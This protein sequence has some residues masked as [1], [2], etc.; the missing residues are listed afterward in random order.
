MKSKIQLYMIGNAHIDPVWLWQRRE[1]LQE[2]KATFRSAV[3][4][5]AEYDDF[6]FTASSAAFYK[7]VELSDPSMFS[8][9][10]QRVAEGRWKITGGYWVE[11][12]CNIPSGESFIRQGLYGQRYFLA[13]VGQRC[14]TGFNIDSFG[15]ASMLPQLLRGCG[16]SFYCFLRPGPH[17]K[18]L[19]AEVFRWE[20]PDGSSVLCQRINQAYTSDGDDLSKKLAADSEFAAETGLPLM[21]F[22]GVGNHGGGP[23][24]RNIEAVRNARENGEYELQFSG[25]DEYF[26]SIIDGDYSVPVQHGELL[27]HASGCYAA[28]SS[29]KALNRRAEEALLT[30][31]KFS[32][33]AARLT[34]YRETEE[35]AFL[36]QELLFNQ[37]HDILAGSSIESACVDA[38][39]LYVEILSR[40]ER[41][42]NAA[43]Q[44]VSWRTNI[45]GNPGDRFFFAANPAAWSVQTLLEAEIVKVQAGMRLLG[46]GGEEVPFQL[47]QSEA[48]AKGRA[49]IVFY[50]RLP[51]LGYAVYRL[52]PGP[53][54]G[55]DDLVY[56]TPNDLNASSLL[57]DS[58]SE[59][60]S[61]EVEPG[62]R[63]NGNGYIYA[64]SYYRLGFDGSR[65]LTEYS[66]T[67]RGGPL[68]GAGGVNAVVM[69]DTSDTWSH[70]VFRYDNREGE[71]SFDSIKVLEDGRVRSRIRISSIYNG[72]LLEQDWI[73]AHELPYVD[74]R[75]RIVWKGSCKTVKLALPLSS[76]I[77]GLR[78][79]TAYAEVQRSA[80]G[81][82]YPHHRYLIADLGPHKPSLFLM[83]DGK[84][85]YSAEDH[86]VYLTIL[87]SPAFSHHV[88]VTL[89]SDID[90]RY[91]DQGEQFFKCR[92]AIIAADEAG[93]EAQISAR[94]FA[95]ELNQSPVLFPE[96][97]HSG[98]LSAASSFLTV[99][100]D[101]VAVTAL[102][103]AEDGGV[104]VLRLFEFCGRGCR[105]RLEFP[106]SS[107]CFSIDIKPYEI[108]TLIIPDNP[109]KEVM[110]ADMLE[111]PLSAG[112][113]EMTD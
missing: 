30:A 103:E 98:P 110:E 40:A 37:F 85:S 4:R 19:P 80:D 89:A 68:L 61:S 2:I 93:S 29:I 34:E 76:T 78:A 27:H 41:S 5:L 23:T 57:E 49:R 95:W 81:L 42:I 112:A 111:F 25:P 94:R 71:F 14:L 86:T 82:E 104:S 69:A 43:L 102:K 1:G 8:E 38:E 106:H 3:D 26:N 59:N 60:R 22:Y 9:I 90:Y 35:F 36:W 100:P 6:I 63:R 56:Q 46:P 109:A 62:L 10:K 7:W 67:G 16:M 21:S 28:H 84:Y 79:E 20:A 91:Q 45:E 92:L 39:H 113:A 96:S 11:P 77:G 33:M 58:R 97:L 107:R 52:T 74:L 55:A 105:V 101:N 73:M 44:S 48:A 18:E 54:P 12:D 50:S 83:N 51:A 108:K 87:R 32:C 13:R 47:I 64:N 31:E 88:P 53:E 75:L 17:E 66:K 24:K 99:T 65:G 70:G 15:H 72:S